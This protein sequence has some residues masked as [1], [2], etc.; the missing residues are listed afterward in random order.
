MYIIRESEHDIFVAVQVVNTPMLPSKFLHLKHLT[1]SM[2][3]GS[4]FSPSYDYFSLVSLF[5][6]SPSLETLFLDV[7]CSS[8]IILVQRYAF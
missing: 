1:I 6:A 7:R 8:Y 3:S 5:D 2:I 4:A